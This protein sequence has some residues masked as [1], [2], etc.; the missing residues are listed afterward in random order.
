MSS[1]ISDA[2]LC[3]AP[4]QCHRQFATPA[5]PFIGTGLGPDPLPLHVR[6]VFVIRVYPAPGHTHLE[7]AKQEQRR[8]PRPWCLWQLG[9]RVCD[10][11]T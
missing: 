5:S 3:S 4:C 9:G 11:D 2:P 7:I 1:H 8:L 6:Y 10:I